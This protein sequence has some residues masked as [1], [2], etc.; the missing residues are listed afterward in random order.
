MFNDI[1]CLDGLYTVTEYQVW[2]C[3]ISSILVSFHK[4]IERF[5]NSNF[6]N[7]EIGIVFSESPDL[8]KFDIEF[9][10]SIETIVGHV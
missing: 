5:F 9:L 8:K 1:W 4:F 7:D 6:A 2:I 3:G 10:S